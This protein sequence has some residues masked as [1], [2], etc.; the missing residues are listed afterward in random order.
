MYLTTLRLSTPIKYSLYLYRLIYLTTLR[1]STPIVDLIVQ[2]LYESLGVH[3]LCNSVI[4]FV[5]RRGPKVFL[6]KINKISSYSTYI[7]RSIVLQSVL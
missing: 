1:L 5:S 2:S 3:H 4:C 7:P 6:R